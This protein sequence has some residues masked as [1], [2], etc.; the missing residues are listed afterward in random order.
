MGSSV[1]KPHVL[2]PNFFSKVVKY[3]NVVITNKQ[4]H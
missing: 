1:L 4:K 2:V 3:A